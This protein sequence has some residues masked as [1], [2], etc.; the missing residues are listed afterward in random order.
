MLKLSDGF[1]G[2]RSIVLPEMIRE[3]EA[4]DPFVSQLYITDMG[5]YPHAAYHFRERPAGVEQYILIYCVKGKG[6]YKLYDKEYQVGENQFFIIPKGT[7]HQY[8]SDNDNPW[9][10]YWL[11]FAGAQAA[12]FGEDY[13]LPTTILPGVTSR[14]TDRNDIFEEIFLT[15]SDN[16]SI[17]NL[18]YCTSLLYG[19]LASF[20]FCQLFRKYNCSDSR[21]DNTDLVNGALHYMLENVEKQLSLR[22]LAAY[23]GYS[24]SQFS[25]VF[26]IKTGRSP[27]NYFNLLKIQ[28]AC[29][30][31]EETNMKINQISCKVGIDDSYYFSRLF[32]KI[33]GVSP[34][35]YR[36]SRT[37]ST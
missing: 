5:Y 1:A 23:I 2:E 33:V 32:T 37:K 26:K 12:C 15:L 4:A 29:K 8:G 16:Y 20:K 13:Q 21:I 14:I 18:R 35:Y 22:E 28:R 3:M 30:L 36:Q 9:T 27:L 17:D 6:H 31:L 7:P 25:A 19:Y 11:H 24:V 10:I 34:K